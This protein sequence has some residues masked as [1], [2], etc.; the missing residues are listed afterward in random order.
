[1]ILTIMDERVYWYESLTLLL[2]YVLYITALIF[3]SK[4]KQWVYAKV[5]FIDQ[6]DQ[7]SYQTMKNS[8]T[9]E[10]NPLPNSATM[11]E[12]FETQ[13]Q[14]DENDRFIDLNETIENF[15][16]FKWPSLELNLAEKLKFYFCWPLFAILYLTVP[17]CRKMYYQ[18]YFLITFT[19]SLVWLCIFSYIMV[20][21]ITVIGYTFSIPDTVMGITFIAFGASVP[22]VFSSLLVAKNGQGDMAIS[23]AIGSNVFD[24]LVCL[25]LPWAVRSFTMSESFIEVKSKGKKKIH[26]IKNHLD[27]SLFFL[28]D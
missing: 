7:N 28:K 14:K 17:D 15:T 25:G 21:M 6:S 4:I 12:D 8:L 1:M 27:Y 24:I 11:L 2:M 5:G 18:K 16:P 22:D 26:F 10:I 13:S 19:M 3:D 9:R 20:W 23:N